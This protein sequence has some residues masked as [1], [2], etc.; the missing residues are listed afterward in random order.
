[1]PGIGNVLRVIAPSTVP[2]G[3]AGPYIAAADEYLNYAMGQQGSIATTIEDHFDG[4]ITQ[5]IT[6]QVTITETEPSPA[7]L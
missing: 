3:N 6:F 7:I 4:T 2:P 1:M 5:N